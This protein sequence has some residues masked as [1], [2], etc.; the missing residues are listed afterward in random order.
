MHREYN[1]DCTADN[2]EDCPL[3][4]IKECD[5]LLQSTLEKLLKNESIKES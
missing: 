3:S 2:C 1:V 5:E 4:G